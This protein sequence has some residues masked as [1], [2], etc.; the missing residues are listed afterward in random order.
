MSTSDPIHPGKWL[1][2]ELERRNIPLEDFAKIVKTSR[3]H[4]KAVINGNMRFSSQFAYKVA[5]ALNMPSVEIMIMQ[6]EHT[7][8]KW[9]GDLPAMNFD[10]IVNS[11]KEYIAKKVTY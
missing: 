7:I 3:A 2:S 8:W 9:R 4:L 1:E 11:M 6:H 5:V 10:D